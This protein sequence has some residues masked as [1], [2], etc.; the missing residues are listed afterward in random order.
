ME[1]CPELVRRARRMYAGPVNRPKT[2]QRCPLTRI[3]DS[4]ADQF[5]ARLPRYV[6]IQRLLEERIATG[7]Y[8]V[9]SLI[10]TEHEFSREFGTSRFTIREAM[11]HLYE[12]GYV[13]RRQGLGTRVISA[14]PKA[15][16]TLSVGSLEELFQVAVDT[17]YVFLGTEKITL[18]TDLAETV[19]GVTDEEWIRIDGIRW[20]EPG[21]RPI[22]YVQS[23]MPGRFAHLLD[24]IPEHRGPLFQLLAED[25]D[26]VIEK[27][28]QEISATP[29]PD[30]LSRQL[31]LGEGTWALRLLRRYV[32][33]DGVLITSINW[34]PADQMTYVMQLHR[35]QAMGN[36]D[37]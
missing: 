10:P 2:G 7:A 28:V 35:Q 11:R 5:T 4:E 32:S 27:A 9:G 23:Y 15:N 18:D 36:A 20:T 24:S 37:G 25:A 34:H 29:M 31:G 14:S 19:G 3:T 22:C 16:Y 8:P 33:P 17:W 1:T 21:G 12:R 13:E 26:A 6:Q 30:R